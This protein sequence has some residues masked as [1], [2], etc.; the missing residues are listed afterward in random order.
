MAQK[1]HH[2][3]AD[4]LREKLREYE[5]L[6]RDLAREKQRL[7]E[8]E[9][10]T[11]KQRRHVAQQLRTKKTELSKESELHRAEALASSAGQELQLQMRLSELQAKYE[12]LCQ[13]GAL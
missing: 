12:K 7:K 13:I 3:E 9:L 5:Q 1:A 8:R 10:E 6:E 4:K 2:T 11:Q